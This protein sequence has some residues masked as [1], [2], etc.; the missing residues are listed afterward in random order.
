MSR[1][2][3]TAAGFGAVLLWA[4]LAVLTV[5][6]APVPPFQ[7][8]AMCFAV[9]AAVG[10]GWAGARGRLGALRG[11][12]PRVWALGVLG[13]WGYH[14]L[15]FT[16]LRLAPPAEAGL[17][18]YLWPLL[19]VLFS[20]LLPGERL[21]RGHVIGALLA[22]LGA[23]LLLGGGAAFSGGAA[24]G[25]AA[26]LICAF[27]WSGY[28]VLSRLVGEAPTEGVAGFCAAAAVLSLIV[29]L[30]V[31]TTVWPGSAV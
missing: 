14:A 16:A 7:L 26:A 4:T 18:A 17:I 15:Y 13:L 9:G 12:G 28:S 30:A 22:A 8:A 31:E 27:V 25:Y 24:P 1:G 11:L 23:G 10:L 6:A 19:I 3:A 2:A 21:R 20:G 5:A 29:H